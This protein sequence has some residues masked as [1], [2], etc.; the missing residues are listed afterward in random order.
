MADPGTKPL[1]RPRIL[2][3]LELISIRR[4]GVDGEAARDARV[5]S[6]GFLWDS[7]VGSVTAEAL[8]GLPLLAGVHLFS[9]YELNNRV[10]IIKR[11]PTKGRSFWLQEGPPPPST[12]T[13]PLWIR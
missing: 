6:R 2:Q 12:P 13:V 1:T 7:G 10:E 9:A 5:L 3:L 11:N 8:A 4:L